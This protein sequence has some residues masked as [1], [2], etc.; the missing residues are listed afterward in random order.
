M[1]IPSALIRVSN[2]SS[3][4]PASGPTSLWQGKVTYDGKQ[5][6][7]N[8]LQLRIT[9]TLTSSENQDTFSIR[10]DLSIDIKSCQ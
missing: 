6:R 1:L 8:K 10:K 5:P 7:P 4:E 3:V 9:M 2:V